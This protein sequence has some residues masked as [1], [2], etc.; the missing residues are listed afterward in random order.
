MPDHPDLAR[1]KST[2]ELD[3]I[4]AATFGLWDQILPASKRFKGK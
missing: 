3:Y 2:R 4:L 1:S